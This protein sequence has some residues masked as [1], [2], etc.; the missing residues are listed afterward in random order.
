[1]F[2]D[3]LREETLPKGKKVGT[4]SSPYLRRKEKRRDR[5]RTPGVEEP[6]RTEPEEDLR[7]NSVSVMESLR[8]LS[9]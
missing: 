4:E 7:S 6:H 1:M 2:M 3:P 5:D 9:F 8:K